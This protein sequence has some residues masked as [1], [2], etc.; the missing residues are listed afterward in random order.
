MALYTTSKWGDPELRWSR[1]A[2]WLAETFP[3]KDTV[4]VTLKK[5]SSRS[6]LTCVGIEGSTLDDVRAKIYWRL[7]ETASLTDIDLPLFNHPSIKDFLYAVVQDQRIPRSAVV[8]SLGFSVS[9]GEVTDVK[10]DVC[11]HCVKRKIRDWMKIVESLAIR[12]GLPTLTSEQ[13]EGAEKVALAFIGLGL[14][15]GFNHRVNLYFKRP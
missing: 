2:R 11:G 8:C 7:T 15:K 3:Q 12:Y 4:A 9:T 13:V 5:V 6:E 10:I 1:T 14:D